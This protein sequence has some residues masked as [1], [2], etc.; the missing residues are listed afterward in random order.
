MMTILLIIAAMM[1]GITILGSLIP[2]LALAFTVGVVFFGLKAFTQTTSSIGKLFW[3]SIVF[4]AL[5]IS[6]ANLPAYLGLLAV[7]GLYYLYT[8]WKKEEEP[9]VIVDKEQPVSSDPFM[10]FEKEW[11]KLT[12]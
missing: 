2:I 1:L 12:K 7:I 6:L 4:V 3:A 10:N 8:N 9:T 11:E 5:M